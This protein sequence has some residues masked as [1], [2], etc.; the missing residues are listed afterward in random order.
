[1]STTV[2]PP[3]A[4]DPTHL[5]ARI[6]DAARASGLTAG[7]RIP[8]E[9]ALAQTYGVSRTSIRHA[10]VLLQA[11]GRLI[12]QVGRGTFLRPTN[13]SD[14]H[15]ER[16]IPL[17]D[18]TPVDVMAVRTLLEPQA[19]TLVVTHATTRDI[20]EM[21][22]CALGGDAAETYDEFEL[23]DTALHRA[24]IRGTHNPLLVYLYTAVETARHGPLWG[25]LKRRH[26]SPRQRDR[27]RD[28]HHAVV[29]AVRAR[30]A[31]AAAAAMRGHMAAISA[32][33]FGPAP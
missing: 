11:D 26:D 23:W 4:A 16:E 14:E 25:E 1:M 6:L 27:Y 3:S 12:R 10:L 13:G 15:T 18:M 31:S 30:D 19:M 22:R 5:A 32:N 33:I 9:R 17:T 21:Q 8:T 24:V 2:E 7:G 29:D 20:D 28:Q